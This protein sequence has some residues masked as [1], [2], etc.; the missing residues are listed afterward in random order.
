MR[1]LSW[2]YCKGCGSV[3][4]VCHLSLLMLMTL[5]ARDV[6][7]AIQWMEEKEPLLTSEDYGK[8]LVSSEALFHS[9][10]RL[11]R[12]LAVMDDKVSF[13]WHIKVMC[14]SSCL[15]YPQEDVVSS[16]LS[17]K[18]RFFCGTVICLL[19]LIHICSLVLHSSY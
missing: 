12:N 14:S 10:K 2:S 3:C 18:E 9:H 19:I 5:S 1:E 13:P 17:I 11:E 16:W 7:E 15:E 4:N 8:D 6:N